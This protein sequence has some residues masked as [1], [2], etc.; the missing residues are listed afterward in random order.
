MR[1][2]IFL[3]N[4]NAYIEESVRAFMLG[5]E[6]EGKIRWLLDVQLIHPKLAKMVQ[7]PPRTASQAWRPPSGGGPGLAGVNGVNFSTSEVCSGFGAERS[8]DFS[9]SV[10]FSRSSFERL[11]VESWAIVD[12]GEWL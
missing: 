12:A 4:A 2:V 8:A 5:S 3:E 7:K 9:M 6:D 1:L 11:R 10:T